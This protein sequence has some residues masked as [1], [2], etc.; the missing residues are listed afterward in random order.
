MNIRVAKVSR[1]TIPG[2]AYANLM[3]GQHN[4]PSFL[5]FGT[6]NEQLTIIAQVEDLMGMQA[7]NLQNLPENYTM[8]FCE[9]HCQYG[10][11][12]SLTPLSRRDVP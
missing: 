3:S 9:R 11:F 10:V 1:L 2:C 7:C 4:G 12:T 8:K 6:A 5:D